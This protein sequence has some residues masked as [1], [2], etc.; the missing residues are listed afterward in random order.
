MNQPLVSIIV[1]TYNSRRWLGEAVD[2]A[3]AQS[4]LNCEVVV[5]DD[6]STDGTGEWLQ[7]QYGS[8]IRYLWKE[9]GGLASARNLGLRHAEGEYIQ[10]LDADD[11]ILPEKV[12]A[13]VE[14]LEQHLEYAVVYCH[15]LCFYDGNPEERFDWWG[16]EFYRSGDVF[17]DMIDVPYILAHATLTRRDWVE[18]AGFFD[19]ELD[20]CVDGDFWLRVAC[21]GGK[22]Y[23]L[24]GEPLALYRIRS[25]SQSAGGVKHRRSMLTVLHK[26]E[27]QVKDPRERKRLKIQRAIGRWQGTYGFS[28]ME[29]G[30]LYEGWAQVARSLLT[31]R[32]RPVPRLTRLALVPF[33]GWERTQRVLRRAK[34]LTGHTRDRVQEDP[35][36]P[37]TN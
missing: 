24:P 16:R 29:A 32:R 30:D 8:R 21:A 31:D 3:L 18:K 14:S 34:L 13:H 28:L 22:F 19:E 4:Y 6:G 36:G 10:F 37:E 20:S 7:E 2:S 25:N 9:N 12:A 15:S 27:K 35:P 5:V 17:A 11:L 23:Y 26:L 1:P 33:L